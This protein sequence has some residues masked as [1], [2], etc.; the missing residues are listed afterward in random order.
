MIPVAIF[1]L[2]VVIAFLVGTHIDRRRLRRKEQDRKWPRAIKPP[3]KVS[4]DLDN[5][6]V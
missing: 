4:K 5:W 3:R 6:M 2:A 1:L